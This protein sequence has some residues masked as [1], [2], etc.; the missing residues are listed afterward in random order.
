MKQV[1]TILTVLA[2]LMTILVISCEKKQESQ[3][4]VTAAIPEENGE[5]YELES[6]WGD[7][8][9]LRVDS[10][11][12]TLEKDTGSEADRTKWA[13]SMTLGEKVSVGEI[14]RLTF[15]GDGVVYDFV[16]VR[17]DNGSVGFGWALQVAKG[18]SLAVVVDEKTNLFRS[19]RA[20]DVSGTIIPSRTLVVYYPET[21]RDGF[22]EI[23]A[24]DPI[25]QTY[26]RTNNNNIRLTSLS[27]RDADIQSAILLQTALTLKDTG[28]E[29]N[30]KDALLEM[31]IRDYPDSLF[32]A[33][34]QKIAN[35]AP[36][37]SIET[38][39]AT[40]PLMFVIDNNVNV[41]AL[42]DPVN[43]RVVGQLSEGESVTVIEQTVAESVIN[44][45]SARWYRI[46]E[47][48]EGWVFGAF[49]KYIQ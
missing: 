48:L 9:V 28:T 10:A 34:I 32:S 46:T 17:R 3:T 49:V 22:V 27:R 2:L 6:G 14:R 7:G 4:P 23:R 19:P 40:M 24:Y 15:H 43:G 16:E 13:A 41:R 20:V 25:S 21:E 45:Q 11:F 5:H 1:I 39:A 35:P 31:A 37:A 8:F 18:G 42:P 38:E 33:E 26:I 47:P 12:Y 36:A 30:R 44:G 29:K